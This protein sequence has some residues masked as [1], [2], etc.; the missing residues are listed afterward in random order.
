[1]ERLKIL[2]AIAPFAALVIGITYLQGYWGYFGVI[3]IPY[4]SFN[5]IL[6]YAA[7]PLFGYIFA[8]MF[9]VLMS[10]VLDN[11]PNRSK[12]NEANA[13]T[14][15]DSGKFGKYRESVFIIL[16]MILC[17]LLIYV[18]NASKWIFVPL[19]AFL[20]FYPPIW[21]GSKIL[22]RVKAYPGI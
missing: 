11:S 4:L 13:E 3:V 18:D 19:V 21:R 14:V 2:L 5:E 12:I 10:D 9:W 15:K 8:T 6:G 20:I 17:G 22:A 1:M 7:V 16:Y